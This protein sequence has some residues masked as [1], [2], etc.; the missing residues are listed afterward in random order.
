LGDLTDNN[1]EPKE[2]HGKRYAHAL[3]ESMVLIQKI[4]KKWIAT[5][6]GQIETKPH[7]WSNS[8][9]RSGANSVG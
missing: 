5:G 4:Q 9:T 3:K 6:V 7:F 2:G 1:F 8:A